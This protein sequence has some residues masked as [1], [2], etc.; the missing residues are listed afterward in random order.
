MGTNL[1]GAFF[2]TKNV[3]PI[4][5]KQKYGYIINIASL[6]GKVGFGGSS[7]YSAS[8]FGMVGFGESLLEEG[9]ADNIRVTTLCPGF[10]ATPMVAGASVSFEEMIPPK[11]IGQ[12]VVTLLHLSENTV[13]KEIVI[14]RKGSIDT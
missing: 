8:K 9:V 10:V 3:L 1:K 13:I 11:D 7:I 12:L 14:H 6:A 5:K 4:M 2:C